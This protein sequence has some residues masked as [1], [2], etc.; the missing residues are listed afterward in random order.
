MTKIGI[1]RSGNIGGALTH[2]FTKAGHEVA[3]ANSRGPDSLADLAR[4]TD[5]RAVTVAQTVP[6]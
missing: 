1:I 3:A 4:E 6:R 5:T 2:L